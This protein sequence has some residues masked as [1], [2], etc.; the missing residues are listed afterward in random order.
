MPSYD[1]LKDDIIKT[2]ENDGTEFSSQIPKFV[3]KAEF[4]LVKDL[5]DFGLDE[6]T[7][8][9]VSSA[10]AGSITINDRDWETNLGI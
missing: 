6:Y 1:D 3:Q 2:S 8:V 9:S 4:R 7:T 5:D 10:N